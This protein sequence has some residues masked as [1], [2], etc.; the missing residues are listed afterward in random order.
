MNHSPPLDKVLKTERSID[1]VCGSSDFQI[2]W[3]HSSDWKSLRRAIQR[4]TPQVSTAR[5]LLETALSAA[6]DPDNDLVRR[7]LAD[8]RLFEFTLHVLQFALNE[9]DLAT[10]HVKPD[11]WKTMA[12]GKTPGVAPREFIMGKA[13]Q[14]L[15]LTGGAFSGAEI[16]A[17]DSVAV[18]RITK[19]PARSRFAGSCSKNARN[20]TTNA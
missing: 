11:L 20:R 2:T 13:N 15:E 14:L 8:A 12:K 16:S 10:K 9:L 6:K 4:V 17:L 7:R 5:T 19:A 3:E 18:E 1:D